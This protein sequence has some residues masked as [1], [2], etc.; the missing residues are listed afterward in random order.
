[1]SFNNKKE[2]TFMSTKIKDNIPPW[3]QQIFNRWKSNHNKLIDR[4]KENRNSNLITIENKQKN[5]INTINSFKNELINY[6]ISEFKKTLNEN[7]LIKENELNQN[8]IDKLAFQMSNFLE[9]DCQLSKIRQNENKY[10]NNKLN[11][12]IKFNNKKLNDYTIEFYETKKLNN[13]K[14]ILDVC[15]FCKKYYINIKIIK[16]NN[17]NNKIF[18]CKCGIHFQSKN[19]NIVCI[20]IFIF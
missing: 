7:N 2:R 15:L 14:N 18:Y 10:F 3:K 5:S 9:I 8:E 13:N 20:F 19:K 1:M 12:I 6:E 16:I 17:K 4:L 11:E